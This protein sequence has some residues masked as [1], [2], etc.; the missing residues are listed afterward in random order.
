VMERWRE[1]PDNLISYGSEVP[2]P[3]AQRVEHGR[4]L[5]MTPG[6]KGGANCVSCHG[7]DGRGGGVSAWEPGKEG[8]E[9]AKDD[10]GNEIQPRDLTRGVFR[11]GRRP[12]DLFRRIYAGINGTPMPEHFGMTI[13]ENG[14][15]RTMTEDDIWDLV[16]FVRTLSAGPM[17]AEHSEGAHGEEGH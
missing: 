3:S 15:Q 9:Y 5:F 6:E 4:S 1:A 2:E 17:V 13:T 8:V 16:F 10:W 11:F 14:E 12:I 7:T